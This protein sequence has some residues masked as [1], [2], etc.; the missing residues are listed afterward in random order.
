MLRANGDAGRGFLKGA[1]LARGSSTTQRPFSRLLFVL[2]LPKQE[3]N[4]EH[5]LS[6]IYPQGL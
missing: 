6:K 5:L 1:A 2:F 4:K 3:K